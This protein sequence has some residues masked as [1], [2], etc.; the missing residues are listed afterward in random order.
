MAKVGFCGALGM[1][2]EEDHYDGQRA[3]A[4]LL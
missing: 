2:P 4:P 1:G 3:G